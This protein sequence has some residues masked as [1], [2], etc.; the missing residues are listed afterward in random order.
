M[1]SHSQQKT[2]GY[3]VGV[4]VDDEGGSVENCDFGAEITAATAASRKRTAV[5]VL[6]DQPVV[7][8]ADHSDSVPRLC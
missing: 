7:F 3:F 8:Q 6:E 2:E 5:S 1:M 4:D